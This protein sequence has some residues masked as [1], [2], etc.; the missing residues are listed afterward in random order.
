M[1][2]YAKLL[3]QPK[4]EYLNSL[5]SGYYADL[6]REKYNDF[7]HHKGRPGQVGGSLPKD[8]SGAESKETKKDFYKRLPKRLQDKYKDYSKEIQETVGYCLLGKPVC[9]ITGKEFSKSKVKLSQQVEMYFK[10]KYQGKVTHKELGDVSLDLHGIKDDIAH[11]I[12]RLKSAAFY[13][14]PQV[15]QEGLIYDRQRNWKGRGYDTFR[16]AAPI[17]IDKGRYVVEVI[18]KKSQARQGLYIHEVGIS[19]ELDKLF[20]TPL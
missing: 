20:W 16:L 5:G 10:K 11:G 15:I 1:N 9:E 19:E 2:Y 18:I 12:G 7:P 3:Q 8:A 6:L 13:A 17:T 4:T 14:V